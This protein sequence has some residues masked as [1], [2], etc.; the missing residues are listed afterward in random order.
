MANRREFLQIGIAASAL[1]SS[2]PMAAQVSKG[3]ASEQ[4]VPFYKA[5][6]DLRYADSI[7]FSQ[8]MAKQQIAVHGINGDITPFWFNELDALWRQE[9]VAVAGLTAHG[10][11]FCLERL[12]W[13]R[14]MRVVY[15]AEHKLQA[16][17]IIEHQLSGPQTMLDKSVAGSLSLTGLDNNWSTG[18]A[19]LM[20][21][22]PLGHAELS[23]VNVMAP[24]TRSE[25]EVG[26]V[27]AYADPLISW[28]IAPAQKVSV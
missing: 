18:L 7:K 21:E 27:D 14:N 8:Q 25:E 13:E 11:L 17:G 20:L 5:V 9:R 19:N 10:P 12:A 2:L 4:F 24:V 3:S 26:E 6:F 1:S 16:G 28:I 23:K 15:R 22:C